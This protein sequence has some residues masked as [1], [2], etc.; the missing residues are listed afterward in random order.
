MNPHFNRELQLIKEQVLN[1]GA[2]V[3]DSLMKAL[4]AFKEKN[5]ELAIK[6]I[7]KD[8]EID[9]L[10]IS[11]EEECLKVLALYHPVASDLRYI[12]AILKINNDLERIGDLAV[13]IARKARY[14]AKNLKLKEPNLDYDDLG[15]KTQGMLKK[16]LDSL[17]E[18]NSK[19]ALEVCKMDAEINSLKKEFR[20]EIISF[21]KKNAAISDVLFRHYAVVRNLE[22]IADMATNI[23]EEVIYIESGEIIR[24]GIRKKI[25]D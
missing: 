13:N 12:V 23:A 2:K 18:M 22:R 7:D 25:E 16:S 10:E 14:L 1:L 8:R 24:H 3:E 15:S 19:A 6:V 9:E 11:I 5:K 4:R 17:V 21:L 20:K